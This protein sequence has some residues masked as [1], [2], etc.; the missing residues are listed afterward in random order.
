MTTPTDSAF[1]PSCWAETV[2]RRI[3]G[4]CGECLTCCQAHG[5]CAQAEREESVEPEEP[6]NL[7]SMDD[8]DLC[9]YIHAHD[10]DARTQYASLLLLA[11][12][13]RRAGQIQDALDTEAMADSI[14]ASLPEALK[15]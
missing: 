15:W 13:C 7:D 12:F 14:Y 9:E 2:A 6:V 1:C 8:A 4:G 11:R 3:C 5:K 10:P